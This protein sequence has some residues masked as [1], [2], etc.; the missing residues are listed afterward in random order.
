MQEILDS[1]AK[2]SKPP[3]QY[4]AVLR[5]ERGNPIRYEWMQWMVGR[6]GTVVK[7]PENGD[8][9]VTF[10]SPQNKAALDQVHRGREEVRRA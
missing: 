5:S 6:G 3:N 8:Y 7:D 10:N 4:G 9:T 2:L 1:C